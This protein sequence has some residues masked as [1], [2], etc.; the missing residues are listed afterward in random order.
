M[1]IESIY[2]FECLNIS[3]NKINLI[4]NNYKVEQ[5]VSYNT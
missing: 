4:I 3:L 5:K 2:C 1:K